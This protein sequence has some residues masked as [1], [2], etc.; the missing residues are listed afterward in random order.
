MLDGLKNL[1]AQGEDWNSGLC[2]P[3]TAWLAYAYGPNPITKAT[4]SLQ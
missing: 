4:T 2:T 3:V 1:G